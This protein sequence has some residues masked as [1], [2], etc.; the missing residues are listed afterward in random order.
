MGLEAITDQWVREG[1]DPLLQRHIED[2]RRRASCGSA[3]TR[4][5][6]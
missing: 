6:R 3:S 1:G 5:F 2:A 4:T